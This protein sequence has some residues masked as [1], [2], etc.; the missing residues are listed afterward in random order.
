MTHQSLIQSG[1]RFTH[2]WRKAMRV[3]S[4]YQGLNADLAQPGLKPG[5]F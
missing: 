1:T 3:K 5:I 2:E 4:L